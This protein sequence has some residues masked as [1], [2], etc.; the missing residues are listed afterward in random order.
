[1]LEE[2]LMGGFAYFAEDG[3]TVGADTIDSATKPDNSSSVVSPSIGCI[4]EM[5]HERVTENLGDR[6]CPKTTGGYTTTARNY[7]TDDKFTFVGEDH[8]ELVHRLQ[9]G[10]SSTI[11]LGTSQTPFADS[12]REV[13]GWIYL[14]GRKQDGTQ[15]VVLESYGKVELTDVPAWTKAYGQPAV[16]FTPEENAGNTI[17]Y[18]TTP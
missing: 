4:R 1:M 6:I 17:V 2:L 5:R 15:L 12:K 8:N 7:I 9:F 13:K 10:L 11:A 3:T 16:T 14:V 18:P